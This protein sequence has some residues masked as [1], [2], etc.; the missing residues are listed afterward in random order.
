M[1]IQSGFKSITRTEG[2]VKLFFKFSRKKFLG[3]HA[4][5]TTTCGV[6]GRK[7]GV[8]SCFRLCFDSFPVRLCFFACRGG[9]GAYRG[10]RRHGFAYHCSC[11]SFCALQGYFHGFF[12]GFLCLFRSAYLSFDRAYGFAALEAELC[13]FYDLCPAFSTIHLFERSPYPFDTEY[14]FTN[15]FYHKTTLLLNEV[16]VNN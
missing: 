10:I 4:R 6:F 11:M 13:S 14:F 1:P 9:F 16:S 5:A 7:T 15:R 12:R 8:F 2:L 3:A